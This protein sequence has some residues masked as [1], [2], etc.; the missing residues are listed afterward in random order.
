MNYIKPPT[1]WLLPHGTYLA[2]PIIPVIVD[3]ASRASH[4]RSQSKCTLGRSAVYL[5]NHLYSCLQPVCSFQLALIA[6]LWT[7]ARHRQL[8][9]K[10]C[11]M[12][13]WMVTPGQDLNVDILYRSRFC[14]YFCCLLEPSIWQARQYQS[15]LCSEN[16]CWFKSPLQRASSISDKKKYNKTKTKQE[17]HLG[18]L[19]S[20]EYLKML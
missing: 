20:D 6:C 13:L 3:L 7:L 2:T 15:I 17:T 12:W 19:M 16:R 14:P 10:T 1:L 8:A 5:N 9:Q 4:P 11:H 18:S